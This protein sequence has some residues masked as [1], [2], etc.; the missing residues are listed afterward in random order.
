MVGMLRSLLLPAFA[1]QMV[2]KRWHLGGGNLG[3]VNPEDDHWYYKSDVGSYG[4]IPFPALRS[5]VETGVVTRDTLISKGQG[6]WRPA[7]LIEG[8]VSQNI[9]NRLFSQEPP[10][11]AQFSEILDSAPDAVDLAAPEV[12][13]AESGEGEQFSYYL[14][15]NSIE[16]GPYTI[17]QLQQLVNYGR[18]LPQDRVRAKD[19]RVWI[20]SLQL[21]LLKFPPAVTATTVTGKNY[22]TLEVAADRVSVTRD[23]RSSRRH[24][25]RKSLTPK[26]VVRRKKNESDE[27][28]EKVLTPVPAVG[29]SLVSQNSFPRVPEND[30]PNQEVISEQRESP[31]PVVNRD[32]SGSPALRVPSKS[33]NRRIETQKSRVTALQ[34]I[35]SRK[36]LVGSSI[37]LVC[38]SAFAVIVFLSGSRTA[39]EGRVT[40]NGSP[41]T[42]AHVQLQ[43]PKTGYAYSAVLDSAGT[44]RL[45]G[46]PPV[47]PGEYA[48]CVIPDF[49]VEPPRPQSASKSSKVLERPDIPKKYHS[50]ATSGLTVLI[51]KGRNSFDIDLTTGNSIETAITK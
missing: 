42:E 3:M 11:V 38:L 50:G 4:P 39:L 43:F 24:P 5:L 8:L 21:D 23:S 29:P 13:A 28:S 19:S 41:V 40:F 12:K 16:I 2:P 32:F 48:V 36:L 37:A 31:T 35:P 30:L 45:S 10:P 15:A 47:P 7:Y 17:R 1:L 6:H 9:L 34:A 44:Y 20:P 33:P 18:L 27:T 51:G 49:D 46:S 14:R 26:P 22:P 25:P